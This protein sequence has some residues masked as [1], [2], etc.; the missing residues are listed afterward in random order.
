MEG[1]QLEAS[2][3]C[4]LLARQAVEYLAKITQYNERSIAER[5]RAS[6]VCVAKTS[7]CWRED[8][9]GTWKR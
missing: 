8:K 1:N 5:N 7:G 6:L 3:T 4:K 9:N 2:G